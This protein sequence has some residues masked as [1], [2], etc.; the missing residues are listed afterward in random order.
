MQPCLLL[1]VHE[2]F[3]TETFYV[4]ESMEAYQK[5]KKRMPFVDMHECLVHK[6]EASAYC[7]YVG[8]LFCTEALL[9]HWHECFA[10]HKH[11]SRASS[12]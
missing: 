5:Y 3:P 1:G 9:P 6:L 8:C 2:C 11:H 10:H 12:L 4:S 7:F